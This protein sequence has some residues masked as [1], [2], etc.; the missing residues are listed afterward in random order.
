M[1]IIRSHLSLEVMEPP[2]GEQ[3]S[4]PAIHGG[5]P[6][7]WYV[8]EGGQ[9]KGP[10][11]AAETFAFTM[12]KNFISDRL[13]SRKGFSQWY[14]HK[15]LSEIY[16]R[17]VAMEKRVQEVNALKQKSMT[18]LNPMFREDTANPREVFGS[19]L[20]KTPPRETSL[21]SPVTP[22]RVERGHV[23]SRLTASLVRPTT[24]VPNAINASQPSFPPVRPAAA[25]LDFAM[26]GVAS[27]SESAAT[28]EGQGRFAKDRRLKAKS[29]LVREYVFAK[30]RLRLGPL[31]PPFITGLIGVPFSLGIYWFY[32]FRGMTLE[33]K[34]HCTHIEVSELPPVWLSAVPLVHI[35]MVYRLATKLR[36][37]EAENHYEFTLP[38]LAALLAI[39]PPLALIYLQGAA[40]KHWL[41][42][43]RHLMSATKPPK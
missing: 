23:T 41:L 28:I 38:W 40:N 2:L 33:I 34:N 14:A 5:W 9:I 15:D 7:G 27:P 6:D 16:N 20:A 3:D 17:T 31:R 29:S 36:D 22:H 10:F 37:M 25:D 24:P 12:E 30:G 1:R 21:L 19:K 26:Y 18:S 8:Y 42:H 13:V 4:N 43:V 39:F 11:S 35:Y 32:W